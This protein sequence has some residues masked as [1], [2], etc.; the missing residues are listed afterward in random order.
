MFSELMTSR[1]VLKPLRLSDSAA[2][3]AYRSDPVV[4]RFQVWEPRDVREVHS[5]IAGLQGLELGT[6]GTWYQ[7]A[8]TLRESGVLI[9][10]C[11]LHFPLEEPK[12]VEVGITLAPAHQRRGYATE[13]LE[14]VIAY[15]FVN[16]DK[17]RVVAR[18]DPRNEASIALLERV[19]MRK[20]GH[21]RES[22]W[23]KGEWADDVIYA[24]LEKEW[25]SCGR[26]G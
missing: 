2:V 19:G 10:D 24:I 17:H 15:L 16:L 25:R 18:V 22:V 4:A 23:V 1:L 20:E 14:G 21:F 7:L 3:F 5:F 12:Q 26:S 13:A 9:G 11:G 6:P 8:I